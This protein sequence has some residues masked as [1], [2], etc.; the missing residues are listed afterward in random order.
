MV[1]HMKLNLGCGGVYKK[2][3]LNVDA[4]DSTIAD[5]KMEAT[6]LL[7]ENNN[8]DRIEMFQV[9]EHLG[10]ARSIY[11]LS[12]CFRV[13]KP[14]GLLILE[15]PDLRKS[16]KKYIEG[17]RED[18][19][20]IL[21]W[22]FGVDIPGYQHRFCFPSDLLKEILEQI[23][24]VEIKIEKIE[25]DEYQPTLRVEC[26]KP[27]D[28]KS[29]QI[30]THFRK[31]ILKNKFVDLDRQIN[32][33]EKENIINFFTEEFNRFFKN[34]DINILKSALIE[35]AVLSPILTKLFFEIILKENTEIFSNK[36]KIFS[37]LEKL[38]EID[39]IKI[40]IENL[41][42]TS[43]FVGKQDELFETI[44]DLGKK[45]IEKLIE[46]DNSEEII[47]KLL[48]FEKQKEDINLDFFSAKLIMLE[49][50]KFFQ[51]GIKEFN[52]ENYKNA[53]ENFER[54]ATLFRNQI[55]TYWNLG[56]LYFILN[57]KE[58]GKE[59]YKNALI[60]LDLFDYENNTMIKEKIKQEINN[61][62]ENKFN[63][64]IIFLH[65]LL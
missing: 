25:F 51:L 3:Y 6:D 42:K 62:I 15:T 39:F 4:F 54:S 44:A 21:P 45:T 13:L 57:D 32:A 12:E 35:G 8:V 14:Y 33:L 43:N 30:I 24:Y 55:L 28:L 27:K 63:E 7:I 60:L 16:F 64:P 65:N 47:S 36:E 9:I 22:I 37:V 52:K 31:Q 1:F 53:V 48:D 10:I 58:R 40:L 56:R 19:K 5:K 41:S 18:R 11:C 23:G 29:F 20:N 49:S 46:E 2:N 34:H 50:N 38:I 26:K 59:N 61:F 17:E